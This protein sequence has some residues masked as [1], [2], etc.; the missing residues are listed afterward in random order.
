[1]IIGVVC[2]IL[3]IGIVV[4]VLFLTGVL[5]GKSKDK[6]S[7]EPKAKQ[8]EKAKDDSK[9]KEKK[10]EQSDPEEYDMSEEEIQDEDQHAIAK[11]WIGE[12]SNDSGDMTYSIYGAESDSFYYTVNGNDDENFTAVMED[13][14]TG[15]YCEEQMRYFEK[16]DNGFNLFSRENGE[17]VYIDSFHRVS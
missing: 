6:S 16:S 3:V 4:L 7:Q 5:G 1:M 13:G 9:K 10:K 12:Y 11:T 17:N 15:A 14:Y 2:S 8:T